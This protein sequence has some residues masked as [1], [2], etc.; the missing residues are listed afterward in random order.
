MYKV[1]LMLLLA[2]VSSSVRAEWVMV[3]SSDASTTY[4]DPATIS[5]AGNIVKMW[6]M[7][8]FK[9][10]DAAANGKA[11]MSMKGQDEFDC[12]REHSR[13]LYFSFYSELKG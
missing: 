7:D 12:K 5:K 6:W 3:G 2:V 8:D 11:Y 9:K 10:A 1:F 13:Q 4:A